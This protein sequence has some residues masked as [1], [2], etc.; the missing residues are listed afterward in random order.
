[1]IEERK[2]IYCDKPATEHSS[3]CQEHL[4]LLEEELDQVAA[5]AGLDCDNYGSLE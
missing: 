4:D 2:C 1:M 3:M 5:M